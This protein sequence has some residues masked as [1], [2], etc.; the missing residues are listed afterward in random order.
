MG[1]PLQWQ[2]DI[3][4]KGQLSTSFSVHFS[5]YHYLC[6]VSIYVIWKIFAEYPPCLAKPI[7]FSG[8]LSGIYPLIFFQK[9]TGFLGGFLPLRNRMVFEFLYKLLLLC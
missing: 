2:R 7:L 6:I 4:P 9:V 5:I 8:D 3:C 1:K